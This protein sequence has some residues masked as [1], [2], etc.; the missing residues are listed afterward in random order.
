M[1]DIVDRVYPEF[2][3]RVE[4]V[5]VNVYDM[6][7]RNLLIQGQIQ[8]IPTQIFIDRF[9]D[10]SQT[11]GVMEDAQLREALNLILEK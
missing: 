5:D 9:G 1:I 8:V 4:L 6:Q 11:V 3:G 7:N 2:E 10:I